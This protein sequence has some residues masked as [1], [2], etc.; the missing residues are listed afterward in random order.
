MGYSD[1]RESGASSPPA[2]VSGRT[3]NE[4]DCPVLRDTTSHA[5]YQ[6]GSRWPGNNTI[7]TRIRVRFRLG[8]TVLRI[9]IQSETYPISRVGVHPLPA[10]RFYDP[11]H[12]CRVGGYLRPSIS[13]PVDLLFPRASHLHPP[14]IDLRTTHAHALQ[15]DLG[16]HAKLSGSRLSNSASAQRRLR[17]MHECG[18]VQPSR[19]A[20]CRDG[21]RGG[22]A[23]A[24]GM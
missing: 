15:P 22:K 3:V 5:N 21:D 24:S 10:P 17:Q 1:F 20:A 7:D 14:R 11:N 6:L 23:G 4:A 2:P 8:A 9:H 16:G 13:C 12:L 18:Q 19:V